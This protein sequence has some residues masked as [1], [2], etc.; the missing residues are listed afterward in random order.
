MLMYAKRDSNFFT[1]PF[2][3]HRLTKI[4]PPATVSLWK[5]KKEV[6]TTQEI[7]KDLKRRLFGICLV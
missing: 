3:E 1:R 6:T 7:P 5:I 4:L 2:G